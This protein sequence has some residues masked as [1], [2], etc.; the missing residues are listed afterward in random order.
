MTN[1]VQTPLVR[2]LEAREC[3][4]AALGII[5][6]Y[7]GKYLSLEELRH[8]CAVTR[9][10]V[11]VLDIV[12]AAQRYGLKAQVFK[13]ESLH[14]LKPPFVIYWGFNH[15]L[16]VEA[17]T[18]EGIQVNDPAYGRAYLS[19]HLVSRYY[20]GITLTFEPTEA[21]TVSGSLATAFPPLFFNRRA[22]V[23][24]GIEIGRALLDVLCAVVIVYNFNRVSLGFGIVY[25][26]LREWTLHRLDM[27]YRQDTF[28]DHVL[29]L[30]LKVF[31]RYYA[32]EIVSRVLLRLGNLHARTL[33]PVIYLVRSLIYVVTLMLVSPLFIIS[34]ALAIIHLAINWYIDTQEEQFEAAFYHSRTRL[35]QVAFN[36]I[37]NIKS[38]KLQGNEQQFLQQLR[39]AQNEAYSEPFHYWQMLKLIFQFTIIP[40]LIILTAAAIELRLLSPIRAVL[41]FCLSLFLIQP[42][43]ERFW[44]DW[45][46]FKHNVDRIRDLQTQTIETPVLDPE[47]EGIVFENVSFGY[48]D[49]PVLENINLHI[50]K[51]KH[52]GLVGRSGSGK[53][54]LVN[55]I[56][57]LYVPS[58]GIV[59][60]KR[61]QF[62]LVDGQSLLINSTITENIRL[63]H[64]RI[65]VE[66]IELAAQTSTLHDTVLRLPEQYDTIIHPTRHPFSKGQL[67]C[68]EIARAVVHKPET[69]LL[70]ESTGAL[71]A[72]TE[73]Q[74]LKNLAS[75]TLVI[76]S[77]RLSAIRDCDEILVMENGK[78]AERGTH[79]TLISLNGIYTRL[80]ANGDIK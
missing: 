61:T 21:F 43:F 23:Y 68:L 9:E 3:G 48:G 1:A 73:S 8:A 49:T 13:R 31:S 56:A 11:K 75:K 62:A 10:G 32:G 33:Q 74:I 64:P 26:V 24:V 65:S 46:G 44:G 4:A 34:L 27:I 38:I 76:V 6:A 37:Q 14:G 36:G 25:L 19:N 58:T 47:V 15:F 18:P 57:G 63:F 5:L 30:P 60:I 67:Q 22:L 16:V 71:D 70:D 54:T 80:I 53:S 66:Q 29:H 17:V 42:S 40:L 52:I 2:Q 41:G 51:G 59:T 55:L 79:E 69:I 45:R 78:I 50:P 20:S 7:Y 39:R 35:D 72:V 28:F 77:H 12:R